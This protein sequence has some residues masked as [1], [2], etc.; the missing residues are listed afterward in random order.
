MNSSSPSSALSRIVDISDQVDISPLSPDQENTTQLARLAVISESE[1]W[2]VKETTF[3]EEVSQT[4]DIIMSIPFIF[5]CT[6][7]DLCKLETNCTV[8]EIATTCVVKKRR[9]AA[10]QDVQPELFFSGRDPKMLESASWTDEVM[11]AVKEKALANGY[12]LETIIHFYESGQLVDW[13]TVPDCVL[14]VN[15]KPFLE[16]MAAHQ[17]QVEGSVFT[18]AFTGLLERAACSTL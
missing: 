9:E 7:C 13:A 12:S 5:V 16:H 8:F 6:L 1:S 11:D 17:H 3:D 4:V 14:G 18:V 15:D 2:S 10:Y